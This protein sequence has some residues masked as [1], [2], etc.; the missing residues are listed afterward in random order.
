MV[1]TTAAPFKTAPSGR[2]S[3]GNRTQGHSARSSQDNRF[4][5]LSLGGR[6]EGRHDEV[7]FV[8]SRLR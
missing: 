4:V 3:V 1:T 5:P 6:L 2:R 7:S 8:V